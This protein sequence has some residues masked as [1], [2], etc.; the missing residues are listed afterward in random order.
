MKNKFINKNKIINN[1][2]EIMMLCALAVFIFASYEMTNVYLDYEDG[3]NDYE[4]LESIF[5]VPDVSGE[6]ETKVDS[7]GNIIIANKNEGAKW[8]WNFDA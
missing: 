3:D 4:D 8:V 2:R 6:T 5:K 7:D 1:I